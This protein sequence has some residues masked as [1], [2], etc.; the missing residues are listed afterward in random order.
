MDTTKRI[1]KTAER[2]AKT[3]G[4]SYKMVIDHMVA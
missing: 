4:D 2:L 3:R 1:N